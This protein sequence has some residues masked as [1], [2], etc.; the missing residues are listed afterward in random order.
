[1]QHMSKYTQ[2]RLRER[3]LIFLYLHQGKSRREIGQLLGRHHTTI[4]REIIRNQEGGDSSGCCS[5]YSASVAQQSSKLR[6]SQ[7]K[8][9]LHKLNDP[10]LKRFVIRKLGKGWSPEQIAGRIK[11]VAPHQQI[12]YETIYRFIYAKKQRKLRLFELLRK[13]HTRRQL[14][15]GRRSQKVQIPGKIF[16]EAR[17]EAA[18]QR[19]EVGHWETDLMEGRRTT[20]ASVSVTVDR[21]SLFTKLTKVTSKQA[22]EKQVALIKDFIN[23]PSNLVKTITYDN[24]TE[25]YLHQEVATQLNCLSY[26]THPYH[27]WEKGT[28]EN[29]I[30][31]VREYLPKGEDL[32]PITQGEL[33]WIAWQL[34]NR[35]R[36]KLGYATPSEIFS[37]ETGWCT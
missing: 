18:T 36:K 1:M 25:N 4:N 28:V 8:V 34:N 24:G 29:T 11:R 9:G 31:L 3:E 23:W 7:A 27:S 37:K 10:A 32:T 21:K 5:D 22:R 14:Q 12:S 35:P 20:K 15:H 2:L 17:P 30:G 19:L 33:S 13:R 6:R 16:I 26:F